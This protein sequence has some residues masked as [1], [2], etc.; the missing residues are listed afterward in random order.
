MKEIDSTKANVFCK[1]RMLNGT[2]LTYQFPNDLRKAMLQSYHEGSLKE[3][4]NGALINVPTTKYNKKGQA[5]LHLGKITQ[6][7]VATH[8]SRWRT[9]GQFLTS[10]NWQ[11][12]LDKADI[13]FLLHDHSFL[14][15]VRIRLDLFK[16][17]SRL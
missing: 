2:R 12:E 7:F 13:R 5:T 15:K 11:G 17:R 10:D 9:R 8:K 1:V 6:V 3:I 16:W 4:L 14:N